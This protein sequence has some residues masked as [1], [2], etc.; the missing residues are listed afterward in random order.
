MAAGALENDALPAIFDRQQPHV[1]PGGQALQHPL[2]HRDAFGRVEQAAFRPPRVDLQPV[3]CSRR[4]RATGHVPRHVRVRQLQPLDA[5]AGV[6]GEAVELTEMPQPHDEAG[7]CAPQPGDDR[8]RRSQRRPRR[9]GAE[10]VALR[11]NPC[12][13]ERL[14]PVFFNV[15]PSAA[16]VK[17]V[18]IHG[19]LAR[20]PVVEAQHA[21]IALHERRIRVPPHDARR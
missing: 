7:K 12:P 21:V 11:P 4:A 20:N 9:I 13:G 3:A 6:G 18:P 5:G 15:P 16:E 19:E 17:R 10:V 14:A 2:Q 8:H 1:E